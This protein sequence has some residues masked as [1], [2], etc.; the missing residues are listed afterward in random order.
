MVRTA[1]AA[2][3]C[4][5]AALSFYSSAIQQRGWPGLCQTPAGYPNFTTIG[6]DSCSTT[7]ASTKVATDG[8]GGV[9]IS[10]VSVSIEA[11]AFKDTAYERSTKPSPHSLV[12]R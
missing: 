8:G 2:D 5:R 3:P 12:S 7:A 9:T 11:S 1:P 10:L 6:Y 4:L